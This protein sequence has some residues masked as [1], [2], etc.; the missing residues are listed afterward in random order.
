MIDMDAV[1][2]R[3][4]VMGQKLGEAFWDDRPIVE[5]I[6]TKWIFGFGGP[7]FMCGNWCPSPAPWEVK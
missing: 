5:G 1:R 6:N 3:E 2:S 4:D 7:L